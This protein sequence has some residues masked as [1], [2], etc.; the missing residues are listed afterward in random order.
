[1]L[2]EVLPSKILRSKKSLSPSSSQ[3]SSARLVPNLPLAEVDTEDSSVLETL[4]KKSKRRIKFKIRP[5]RKTKTQSAEPEVSTSETPESTVTRE[6]DFVTWKQIRAAGELLD[7]ID[8]E[9]EPVLSDLTGLSSLD[10]G[11]STN[12]E[13][14]CG[15]RTS[16]LEPQRTIT[17]A[18]GR[19]K[20]G[21]FSESFVL[22]SSRNVE[23]M[24][25]ENVEPSNV[26]DCEA[27]LDES[28]DENDLSSASTK[29]FRKSEREVTS[30][31]FVDSLDSYPSQQATIDSRDTKN[32]QEVESGMNE[33][34]QKESVKLK[35]IKENMIK[36]PKK[37]LSMPNIPDIKVKESIE[38]Q[39]ISETKTEK[40]SIGKINYFASIS[41]TKLKLI[42]FNIK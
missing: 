19:S 20:L 12:D 28:E 27:K 16:K 10:D 22:I 36:H 14:E 13:F 2:S 31:E 21:N 4:E 11:N 24:R 34:E 5:P 23:S 1:M 39:T 18:D 42:M 7:S 8:K 9:E 29:T 30:V 37:Y 25:L 32:L 41:I 6:R 26:A 15:R 3:K 38:A 17:I 33:S 35:M 40:E